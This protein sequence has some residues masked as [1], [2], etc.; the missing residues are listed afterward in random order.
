[1]LKAPF[2]RILDYLVHL[3]FTLQVEGIILKYLIR[4]KWENLLLYSEIVMQNILL[5]ANFKS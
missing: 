5:I 4:D 3:A 2:L 1:M